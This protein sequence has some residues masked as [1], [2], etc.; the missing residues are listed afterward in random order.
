MVARNPKMSSGSVPAGHRQYVQLG[1]FTLWEE[2]LRDVVVGFLGSSWF[3]WTCGGGYVCYRI[4][5]RRSRREDHWCV[6]YVV[7]SRMSHVSHV[8]HGVNGSESFDASKSGHVTPSPDT[9][10]GAGGPSWQRQHTDPSPG[11]GA[12]VPNSLS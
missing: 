6:L 1:T 12:F 8:G 5:Q 9:A 7:H 10:K 11:M 4:T 3:G 2:Q